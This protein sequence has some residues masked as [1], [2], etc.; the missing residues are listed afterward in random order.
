MTVQQLRAQRH[1]LRPG[2]SVVVHGAPRRRTEAEAIQSLKAMGLHLPRALIASIR[3]GATPRGTTPPTLCPHKQQSLQQW[4]DPH[5]E[6]GSS[7]PRCADRPESHQHRMSSS[8]SRP[9]HLVSPRLA[10]RAR[11]QKSSRPRHASYP[12]AQ[13]T[14]STETAPRAASGDPTRS[15]SLQAP[16]ASPA[17]PRLRL[18]N[19]RIAPAS[20]Q[21][22]RQT[23]PERMPEQT[24]CQDTP[25]PTA[26]PRIA[27][28]DPAAPHRCRSEPYR[29]SAQSAALQPQLAPVSRLR[30]WQRRPRSSP[31]APAAASMTCRCHRRCSALSSASTTTATTTTDTALAA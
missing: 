10:H 31:S 8:Q 14:P 25:L 16:A 17:M 3:C 5:P 18:C 6:I 1:R 26:A 20:R 27:P 24:T 4:W 30:R 28:G 29:P 11:R 21:R 22:Q 12:S 2:D 9:L 7:A 23:M 13:D 15:L 19:L